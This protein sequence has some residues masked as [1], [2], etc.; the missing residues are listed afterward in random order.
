MEGSRAPDSG[1]CFAH[2]RD[3]NYAE[4]ITL[5]HSALQRFLQ[6]LLGKEEGK[7]GRGEFGDLW[8]RAEKKGLLAENGFVRNVVNAFKSYIPQERATNSTAKPAVKDTS[9]EEALL[10]LNVAMI[11]IQFCLSRDSKA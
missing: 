9:P 6:V 2:Y 8:K 1:C 11:F 7:N 4:T 10:M 3:T 5:T